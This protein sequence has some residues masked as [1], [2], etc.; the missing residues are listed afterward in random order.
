G[1]SDLNLVC[2]C[3]THH[4]QVVSDLPCLPCEHH[5]RASCLMDAAMQNTSTPCKKE[6]HHKPLDSLLSKSMEL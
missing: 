6:K 3:K 4:S 5:S 1:V 2:F